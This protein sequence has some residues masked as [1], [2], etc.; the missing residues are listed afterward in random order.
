MVD[1]EEGYFPDWY[2]GVIVGPGKA[3]DCYAVKFDDGTVHDFVGYMFIRRVRG[4]VEALPPSAEAEVVTEAEALPLPP[5][6]SHAASMDCDEGDLV[7]PLDG[8][9]ALVGDGDGD[10]MGGRVAKRPRRSC[11]SACRK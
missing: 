5:P 7:A 4:D 1:S 9:G 2:A 6:M 8:G 3:R 10:N 11:P